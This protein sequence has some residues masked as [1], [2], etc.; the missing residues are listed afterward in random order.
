[1]L[2]TPTAWTRFDNITVFEHSTD[3][4]PLIIVFGLVR[5]YAS[6][7]DSRRWPRRSEYILLWAY[8]LSE[9]QQSHCQVFEA[10]FGDIPYEDPRVS[11]DGRLMADPPWATRIIDDLRSMAH[12]VDCARDVFTDVDEEW[13]SQPFAATLGKREGSGDFTW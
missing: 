5:R 12:L 2:H 8:A 7:G 9:R 11:N 13:M 3:E 6:I 10:M 4:P 1:M